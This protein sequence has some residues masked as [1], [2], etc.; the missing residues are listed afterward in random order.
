M[1]TAVVTGATGFLGG[2]IVRLLLENDY[3]VRALY[4]SEATM[5]AIAELPIEFVQGDVS[6]RA[7]LDRAMHDAPDLVFHVAASTAMW[8]PRSAQQTLINVEGTRNVV[9]SALRAKVGRLVH[10]SSVAVYG[11]T[12]EVISETSPHLGRESWINYARSKA[13]GEDAV[14][15][16]IRSG[17]DAVPF[18]GPPPGTRAIARADL[19]EGLKRFV[20]KGA[21]LV[22]VAG[23]KSGPEIVYPPQGARV[24]LAGASGSAFS[25]L[26][27]K[28][29]GGKAPFRWLANGKPLDGLF[30]RRTA[31]WMPDGK[32]FS[33]LTVID[34][35]GKATT[36]DVLIQ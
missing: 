31:T 34:A 16:G 27:L 20:P 3:K 26:V 25:P 18:A 28:L 4:R 8:K 5:A 12:S 23:A 21:A 36:V 17:L 24:E 15:A 29:Q 35:A 13:L 33:K 6:D 9:Q 1:P 14:H 11:L 10:T 22:P 2:H 30:R 32:G 19:P 7:S